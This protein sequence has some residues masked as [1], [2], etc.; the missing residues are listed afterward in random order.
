MNQWH[1]YKMSF[2]LS[3]FLA[4]LLV[5]IPN[6][7]WMVFPPAN[8]LLKQ[9]HAE[10]LWVDLLLNVSQCCMAA[11]LILCVSR[12]KQDPYE[13]RVYQKWAFICLAAYYSCWVL[14]YMGIAASWLMV[15][16][17]VFPMLFFVLWELK[18]RN[19]I[20]LWPSLI[21]A[22]THIIVTISNYVG[23]PLL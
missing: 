2:S 1:N 4:F 8:D 9:N 12:R 17:A 3:G 23:K 21:F 19:Y 22:V 14:Y 13:G 16:M 18:L 20:A 15:C 7:V 5:M 6:I 11:S 10:F